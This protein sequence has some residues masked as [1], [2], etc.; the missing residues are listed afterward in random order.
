MSDALN[1]ESSPEY[2]LTTPDQ[3]DKLLA[4]IHSNVPRAD[5]LDDGYHLD[6]MPIPTPPSF[7]DEH[8]VR[9][10]HDSPVNTVR[11]EAS[12]Q[13]S[14]DPAGRLDRL[15]PVEYI[16]SRCVELQEGFVL[17]TSTSYKLREDGTLIERNPQNF[18]DPHQVRIQ[19][20]RQAEAF[21]TQ[22][23]DSK[24]LGFVQSVVHQRHGPDGQSG[25]DRAVQRV[26]ELM[27]QRKEGL[28][29]VTFEEAD[30]VLGLIRQYHIN[31]Q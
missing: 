8:I 13:Y 23:D 26:R 4:L 29:T 12:L 27:R 15:F 31:A 7:I 6:V 2:Y 14:V 24:L 18:R 30:V 17:S 21:A 5:A 3:A 1:F 22:V 11:H 19:M 16:I 28:F 20:L 25:D 9:I 10:P